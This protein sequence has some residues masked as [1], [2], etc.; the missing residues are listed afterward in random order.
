MKLEAMTSDE[1]CL[2]DLDFSLPGYPEYKLLGKK[3]LLPVC[4][5]NV[6]LYIE[7]VIDA[8]IGSGVFEQ[9]QSFKDGFSKIIPIEFFSCFSP[10]ELS[11]IISGEEVD[12]WTFESLHEAIQTDH[13]YQKDSKTIVYFY[14]MLCRF[15]TEQRREFLTFC[16][17]SPRLPL[18]GLAALD[19]PLTVVCKTMSKDEKSDDCLPSVMTCAHYLKLPEY[20]SLEIMTQKFHLAMREGQNSFHLS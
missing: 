7:K 14:E 17:G 4:S 13:G 16:T 11:S 20:S 9:I 5:E 2:L 8:T 6:S 15:T 1:L 3:S 18:G 12:K 19:P 10:V